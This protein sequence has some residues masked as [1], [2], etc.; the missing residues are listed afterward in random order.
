MCKVRKIYAGQRENVNKKTAGE[1]IV[2]NQSALLEGLTLYP[3][4]EGLQTR[5]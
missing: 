1:V 2:S 3:R 4:A 5:H